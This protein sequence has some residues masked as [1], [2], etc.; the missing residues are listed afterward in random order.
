MDYQA[1]VCS[2]GHIASQFTNLV[3]PGTEEGTFPS[4]GTLM[5]GVTDLFCFLQERGREGHLYSVTRG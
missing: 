2:L 1:W 4:L 3:L 5:G